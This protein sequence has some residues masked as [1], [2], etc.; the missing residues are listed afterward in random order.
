MSRNVARPSPSM[1]RGGSCSTRSTEQPD[2][3]SV[4]MTTTFTPRDI[5]THPRRGALQ[6]PL[7]LL[8]D[9]R[10][11]PVADLDVVVVRQLDAALEA[12]LDVL[13]VF[14]D[15]AERLDR[16]VFGDHL[17]VADQADLAAALDVA[18]RHHAPADV[19]DLADLEHLADLGV[20]VQLLAH[21]RL[22]QAAERLLQVVED[23]VDHAVQPDLDAP[24]LR[25]LPGRFVGD[26]VEAD[27]D[28]AARVGQ[29]DVALR[30][31]ADR[32]VDHADPHFLSILVGHRLR[33]R[34]DRAL[35]VALDDQV[36][37]LDVAGLH[38]VEQVVQRHLAHRREL[39][40]AG[41]RRTFFGDLAG[42]VDVV[43]DVEPI[44]RAG[45]DVQP[46]DDDRRARAGLLDHL[47][48]VV[49]QAAD[50]AVTGAGEDRVA[51]VERAVLNEHGRDG[52]EAGIDAR[53]D[54]RAAGRRGRVGLELEQRRLVVEDL[55]QLLDALAG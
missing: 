1:S 36:D 46:A 3:A 19:A 13:H 25:H 18:I 24:L 21:F 5:A 52:A 42:A 31:R 7:D 26:D 6:R 50:A 51:D 55:D 12:A 35:D 22:E 41:Q 34:L 44:A 39:C 45:E 27:D 30:D 40:L 47:A 15:A 29:L 20:A 16:E 33:Q 14:L 11:Q 10:L 9:V 4:H 23:L 32:A 38:R 8:A 2:R 28:R 53:L 43:E 54:H 48:A 17:A 49:D 37:R